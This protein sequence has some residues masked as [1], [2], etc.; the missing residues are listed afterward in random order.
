MQTYLQIHCGVYTQCFFKS[1]LL[2]TAIAQFSDNVVVPVKGTTDSLRTLQGYIRWIQCH[3]RYLRHWFVCAWLETRNLESRTALPGRSSVHT[4]WPCLQQTSQC[5]CQMYCRADS[6]L[7]SYLL[8]YP[9][10]LC[11]SVCCHPSRPHHSS[12]PCSLTTWFHFGFFFCLSRMQA[13]TQY[14]PTSPSIDAQY[15]CMRF[16]ILI[17]VF[18][19]IVPVWT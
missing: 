17:Q 9:Q 3:Q 14:L 7:L 11:C 12:H 1:L 5:H 6:C 15:W 19:Y 10:H 13:T 16:S 4:A 2:L 8:P 18:F